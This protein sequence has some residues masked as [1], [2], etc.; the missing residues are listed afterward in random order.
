MVNRA[1]QCH[2]AHYAARDVNCVIPD[3]ASGAGF[4]GHFLFDR[5]Q[6]LADDTGAFARG[7]RGIF[8]QRYR[9][10]RFGLLCRHDCRNMDDAGYRASYR[11]Y[12]SVFGLCICGGDCR[13]GISIGQQC[14]VMDGIARIM[15]F[16]L[17]RALRHR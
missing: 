12:Q 14:L 16:R 2:T 8:A 4:C 10:D 3:P 6:W 15:W 17:W 11:P 1:E 7:G 13:F 9:L 5:R